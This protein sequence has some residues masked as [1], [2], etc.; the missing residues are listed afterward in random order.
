[1]DKIVSH[2]KIVDP[3]T[4]YGKKDR[5][6]SGARVGRIY[7]VIDIGVDYYKISSNGRPVLID[8]CFGQASSLD[9]YLEQDKP[10]REEED[11]SEYEE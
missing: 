8:K 4:G 11:F 1:M 7:K 2:V 10:I 3:T 6:I 5:F 9:Q